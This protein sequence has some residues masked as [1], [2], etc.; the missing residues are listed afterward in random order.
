MTYDISM[1]VSL[2]TI[3]AFT[4]RKSW[5]L[6]FQWNNRI[7]HTS[8]M[9]GS[10]SGKSSCEVHQQRTDLICDWFMTYYIGRSRVAYHTDPILSGSRATGNFTQ[11]WQYFIMIHFGTAKGGPWRQTCFWQKMKE[12]NQLY[13]NY[14]LISFWPS[15][16]GN[17]GSK[18]S[19]TIISC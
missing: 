3:N 14:Q 18:Q 7:R 1:C 19:T 16:T 10:L 4:K 13:D 11:I 17:Q 12:D 2:K 8:K 6:L 15:A 5:H 9:T